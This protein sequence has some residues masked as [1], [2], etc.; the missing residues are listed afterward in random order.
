M[1]QLGGR[2]GWLVVDATRVKLEG[3]LGGINGD[4]SWTNL[5][6]GSE[7]SRLGSRRNVVEAGDGGT[8]VGSVVLAGVRSSGGVRVGSLSVNSVVRDDVLESLV[9]K[10]TIASFV[11]LGSRA[12]NQVL[13]R[14][15]ET[16]EPCL[17]NQAPSIDPVAEK[18][19]HDPH[20]PWF[21]IGVTAPLVLQSTESGAWALIF[22]TENREANR[23]EACGMR[24]M[25]MP[26]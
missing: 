24:E 16:S 11:S 23:E 1:I 14:E 18:D 10:S 15:R 20:W 19:Q 22:L 17:R 6:D 4:G 5:P 2:A 8:L 12:V 21:L 13:L 3:L 7:E 26:L 9:H 25:F